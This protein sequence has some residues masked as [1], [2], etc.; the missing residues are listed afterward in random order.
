MRVHRVSSTVRRALDGEGARLFGGRWNRQGTSVVYTSASVALALLEFIVHLD[1]DALPLN[2]VIVEA[3]LPDDL[4]VET[5]R[6]DAL[7]SNWRRYR[8]PEVLQD[9][10]TTWVAERRSAV[11]SVPSVIVPRERN[12]LLNPAHP[13]FTRIRVV[14]TEPFEFDP[15]LRK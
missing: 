7:P 3:D 9:F 1:T 5:V 15:R 6:A 10:G 11:L 8:G 4:R 2:L 12:Y 14:R 13:D